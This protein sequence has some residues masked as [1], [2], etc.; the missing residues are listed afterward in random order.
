MTGCIRDQALEPY[1]SYT[2]RR[3]AFL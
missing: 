1:P 3:P 2:R